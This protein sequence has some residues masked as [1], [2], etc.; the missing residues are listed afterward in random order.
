M[1]KMWLIAI[2]VLLV[3]VIGGLGCGRSQEEPKTMMEQKIEKKAAAPMIEETKEMAEEAQ[4]PAMEK[5]QEAA[6]EAKAPVMEEA[7]EAAEQAKAEGG[8][9]LLD[10]MKEKAGGEAK[11]AVE[12]METE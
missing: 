11:K 6:E 3:L 5:A 7:Q 4:A 2:P 8:G 10:T 1:K 9:A 12:D